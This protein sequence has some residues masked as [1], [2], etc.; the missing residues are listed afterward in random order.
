MNTKQITAVPVEEKDFAG[1]RDEKLV[2]VIEQAAANIQN[3]FNV[4]CE[5]F[6][7]KFRNK[8]WIYLTREGQS[9]GVYYV[10]EIVGLIP[11]LAVHS[12]SSAYAYRPIDYNDGNI[13]NESRLAFAGFKGVIPTENEV[14]RLFNDEIKYFRANDGCIKVKNDT[15]NGISYLNGGQYYY[16]WTNN[17]RKYSTNYYNSSDQYYFG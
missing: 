9:E 2:K 10:N 12:C 5:E 15:Q 3:D 8:K 11:D 17:S 1:Y 7:E 14:R 13:L 6:A 16:M 4:L